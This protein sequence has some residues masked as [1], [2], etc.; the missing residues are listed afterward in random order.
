MRL[1][2]REGLPASPA[3]IRNTPP[4]NCQDYHFQTT[5]SFIPFKLSF[6]FWDDLRNKFPMK[7][8][9][10]LVGHTL[11]WD[12][13]RQVHMTFWGQRGQ[14]R[15]SNCLVPDIRRAICSVLNNRQ[16][17]GIG[18]L[19]Q[20]PQGIGR[21]SSLK[22]AFFISPMGSFQRGMQILKNQY[23]WQLDASLD[24]RSSI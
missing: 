24:S 6:H 20:R 21:K 2:S 8:R 23:G 12:M 22:M 4:S 13:A 19:T 18:V 17:F 11:L 7:C 14:V 1:A 16:H 3:F 15:G 9:Y 10:K 5:M